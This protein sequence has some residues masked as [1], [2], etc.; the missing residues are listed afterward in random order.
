MYRN[1]SASYIHIRSKLSSMCNVSADTTLKPSD[2]SAK[3]GR[4][5]RLFVYMEDK[6][7]FLE[8][9]QRLMAQRLLKYHKKDLEAY[10]IDRLEVDLGSLYTGKLD[11][12]LKDIQMSG[13]VQL[14]FKKY[15]HSYDESVKDDLMTVDEEVNVDSNVK[16]LSSKYWP[17]LTGDQMRLPMA[18]QVVERSFQCFFERSY[19]NRKIKWKR[20][21][22]DVELE[23]VLQ[24]ARITSP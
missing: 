2:D 16:V 23:A 4:I 7:G 15:L 1:L 22:C 8:E 20:L 10:F 18:M 21:Q 19:C 5:I 11:G 14:D 17:K 12:M 24:I 13:E 9:N 6:G 3:T